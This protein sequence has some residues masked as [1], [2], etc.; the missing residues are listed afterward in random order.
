MINIFD[1]S[2]TE[3][4][5]SML[6]GLGKDIKLNNISTKAILNN[7]DDIEDTKIMKLRENIN[8][9]DIVEYNSQK[10][11][12]LGEINDKRYKTFNRVKIQ[13]LNHVIKVY[14]DNKLEE[15]P[16]I[17]EV[18]KEQ[19]IK[20][21]QWIAIPDGS[22]KIKIQ[23]NLINKKLRIDNKFIKFK[24]KWTIS[25]LTM[26]DAG[27]IYIYAEKTEFSS[28]DNRE[29]EIADYYKYQ[30][31]HS[32]SI[33]I[34]TILNLKLNDTKQLSP[35]VKDNGNIV[36]LPLVYTSS[37]NSIA[38]IDQNGLITA[39]KDGACNIKVGL[40]DYPTISQTIS[41]SVKSSQTITYQ[42]TPTSNIIPFGM[43][44]TYTIYKYIDSEKQADTF[45]FKLNLNGKDPKICEFI[46]VD[47]NKFTINAKKNIRINGTITIELLDT[48]NVV[49]ATKDFIIKNL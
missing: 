29:L 2:I 22:I 23:D 8:R 17:I 38:T 32:Y 7:T 48:N 47:G 5:Q 9:G 19:T 46:V 41:L 6:D 25:G 45:T 37:D 28:D 12:C 42:Y 14:I 13:K 1:T 39:I 35:I 4:F 36:S 3:D 26:E 33:E 18:S 40:R 20:E 31:K 15:I 43:S 10:F 16:C 24:S 34:D 49:V 44:K 21:N 11:I 30:V 27:L